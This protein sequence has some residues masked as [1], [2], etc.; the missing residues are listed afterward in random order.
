[1]SKAAPLTEKARSRTSLWRRATIGVHVDSEACYDCDISDLAP[2][3]QNLNVELDDID[4]FDDIY[5]CVGDDELHEFEDIHNVDDV[6]RCQDQLPEHDYEL[7]DDSCV[8]WRWE[9]VESESDSESD[10]DDDETCT[11]VARQLAE[12]MAVDN[13]KSSSVNKLLKI[14]SPHFPQ[15]PLDS[16]TLTKTPLHH[17][18]VEISGGQYCHI[19]LKVVLLHFVR[20]YSV[21]VDCLELQINVDGVPLFRSSNTSLWP[22]L[23]LIR[24]VAAVEPFLVGLFCGKHKPNNPAEF[25]SPFV[26]EADN[27]IEHG[28]IVDDKRVEVK[29]HSFVCDAPARAFLKGIKSHS[30]YSSCEKCIVHGEYAGKVIFPTVDDPLHTDEDFELMRDENHHIIPC[31]LRPLRVGFVSQFGIDYMHMACLGVMRRLLLYWKGPVGPLSVRL[32]RNSVLEISKHLAIFAAHSPVEFARKARS[33]DDV[34]KWKATEF[35]QLMLYSGPF[36]LRGV[37]SDSVYKHFLLLYVGLRILSCKQLSAAYCDYANELL[38]KFV[39][40]GEVH[41]GRSLLVYNVHSLV[42]LAA[43]V[44]KLGCIQEFSAFPFES[45][46]GHIKKL[47]HKP[48]NP[49][50]QILR[51]LDAQMTFCNVSEVNTSPVVKS[52]HSCGPLLP[53]F[54]N[55]VQYKRVKT[56]Q[57]VLALSTGNNC[58]LTNAGIPAVVKN[59]VVNNG[60]THILCSCYRKVSDAF[61]YPLPSSALRI[62]RVESEATGNIIAIP[63]GDV[64]C[65]CVC[66]PDMSKNCSVVIP[67]LHCK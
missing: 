9:T 60:S 59:I 44:K 48:Q 20:R 32:P 58:I 8:G 51:R 49:I 52:E 22:I 11:G 14:L 13:I 64:K 54:A 21:V 2:D 37:L 31:P 55:A 62:F 27:L 36:I 28:L 35:R 47:V 19:G 53:G 25:L 42:H 1:M 45:K 10:L 50:Q 29:I 30:G 7:Y 34:L 61:D 24:N 33:V 39:K 66:F 40:D 16:R 38:V 26:C 23:C 12:W 65:K 46:L 56:E 18:I 57:F 63:L 43:D 17:D 5:M 6:D 3:V 67:L 4:N 41:Y 15:L